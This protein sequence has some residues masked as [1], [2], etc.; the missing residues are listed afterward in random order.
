MTIRV[1]YLHGFA[2]SPGSTKGR[3]LAES[4]AKRGIPFDQP[5][6]NVPT[7]ET[8]SIRAQLAAVRAR[9]ESS[10]APCIVAGSSLGGYVTA[11]LASGAD[12]PLDPRVRALL[13]IAPAFQI[14]ERWRERVGPREMARWRRE[15]NAV[16]PHYARG[17]DLP[18]HIG[19]LDEAD[20]YDPMPSVTLPVTVV[21]G[22][23]DETVP[24][25]IA[26]A[27]VDR[28]RHAT[29]VEV[30]DDHQLAASIPRIDQELTALI[31]RVGDR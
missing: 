6:L 4:F 18:L 20:G 19:F 7:F 23:R 30:D 5:D 28:N 15:G 12:A 1:V 25:Q 17:V 11:L 3:T 24:P 10:P 16:H 27:W 2:S 21:Q 8:L 31:A 26:R 9:I 13:L 14:A 29:L 22:R